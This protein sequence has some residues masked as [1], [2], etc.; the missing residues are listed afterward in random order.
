MAYK[1]SSM[2]CVALLSIFLGLSWLLACG[3]PTGGASEL[4]S[5]DPGW[6][7]VVHTIKGA[8]RGVGDARKALRAQLTST[9]SNGKETIRPVACFPQCPA[10]MIAAH[11]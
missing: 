4:Q 11:S 3:R 6:R 10:A 2:I 9:F 7:D 5:A 8:A 1:V